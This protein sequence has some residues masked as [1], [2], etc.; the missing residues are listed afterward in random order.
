VQR[1]NL[2]FTAIDKVL[3]Y[4][5]VAGHLP[6]IV[7]ENVAGR[8]YRRF[9]RINKKKVSRLTTDCTLVVLFRNAGLA[10]LS[11]HSPGLLAVLRVAYLL[12]LRFRL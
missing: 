3:Q 2:V 9:R 1:S 8:R 10:D 7:S 11:R 6:V 12:R 5:R 4:A